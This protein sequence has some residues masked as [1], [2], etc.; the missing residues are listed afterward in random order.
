MNGKRIVPISVALASV[1]AVI[2][3]WPTCPGQKITTTARNPDLAS[4][5]G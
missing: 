1:A 4:D 3:F 5:F 2:A